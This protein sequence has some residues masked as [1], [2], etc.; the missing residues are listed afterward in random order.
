MGFWA[1]AR[2]IFY[3]C[4]GDDWDDRTVLQKGFFLKRKTLIIVMGICAELGDMHQ[5]YI[6]SHAE[7]LI[8]WHGVRQLDAY[9]TIGSSEPSK[10]CDI[11]YYGGN[12]G[13]RNYFCQKP[14]QYW[15]LVVVSTMYPKDK[16]RKFL[17]RGLY[18]ALEHSPSTEK[19][20]SF[21]MR[22]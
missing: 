3:A 18:R 2:W 4:L 22:T 15:S 12:S 10:W 11:R 5:S 1:A 14:S 9:Q 8:V 21:W 17:P 16:P 20:F 19:P 13:T 7:G 6:I